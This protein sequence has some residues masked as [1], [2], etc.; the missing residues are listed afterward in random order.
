MYKLFIPVVCLLSTEQFFYSLV[1]ISGGV[2]TRRLPGSG[3]VLHYPAFIRTQPGIMSKCAFVHSKIFQLLHFNIN[4]GMTAWCL[5]YV[6]AT[7]TV[8]RNGT[9]LNSGG[10]WSTTQKKQCHTS[11]VTYQ[12]RR[13]HGSGRVVMT[14]YPDPVPGEIPYPSSLV[15]I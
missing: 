15:V 12:I 7:F 8:M 1:V 9:S 10:G 5:V 14:G 3:R 13:L 11:H 6:S 2:G 4:V